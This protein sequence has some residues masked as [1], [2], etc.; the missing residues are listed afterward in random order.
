MK[1]LHFEKSL[2]MNLNVI[3]FQ[4]PEYSQTIY[5]IKGKVDVISLQVESNDTAYIYE[6]FCQNWN[7]LCRVFAV[8]KSSNNIMRILRTHKK[9]ILI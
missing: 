7:W 2:L 4:L 1:N 9:D 5:E 6:S 3:H 8:S